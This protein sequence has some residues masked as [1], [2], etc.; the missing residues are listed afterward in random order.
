MTSETSTTPYNADKIG[1]LSRLIKIMKGRV[2]STLPVAES[3]LKSEMQEDM[4]M[5]TVLWLSVSWILFIVQ[6]H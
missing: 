6:D 1:E 3:R 5:N 2:Y 4:Q